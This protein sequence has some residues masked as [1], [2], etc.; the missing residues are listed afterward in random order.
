MIN[1]DQEQFC[2]DLFEDVNHPSSNAFDLSRVILGSVGID[3]HCFLIDTLGCGPSLRRIL[4]EEGW[5]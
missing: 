5:S 2:R 4:Q 1:T 3:W